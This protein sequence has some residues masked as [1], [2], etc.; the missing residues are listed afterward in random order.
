MKGPNREG[1]CRGR[2]DLRYFVSCRFVTCAGR[3]EAV[4]LRLI[5][6]GS[7]VSAAMDKALVTGSSLIDLS[8]N[9]LSTKLQSGGNRGLGDIFMQPF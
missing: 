6:P 8:D 9:A 4:P 7:D 5:L 2:E 1:V 3:G